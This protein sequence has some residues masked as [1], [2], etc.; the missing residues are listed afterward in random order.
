[1]PVELRL[2]QEGHEGV[3]WCGVVMM[4]ENEAVRRRRALLQS[5]LET[6]R[7]R[8]VREYRPEQIWIFG[9]L[10]FGETTD[11]SDIDLLIV[12]ETDVRF[13]DRTKEVLQLLRPRVG[14][15][16]LVYTPS[17]FDQLCRE[18]PFFRREILGKGRILYERGK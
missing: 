18:R 6:Y 7:E 11:W 15:D 1:M 17:E 5:E 14:M 9:S 16:I 10:A 8:L 3:E 4:S 2:S 12:K 13:L